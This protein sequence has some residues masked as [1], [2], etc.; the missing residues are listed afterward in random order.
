MICI[1]RCH[2]TARAAGPDGISLPRKAC[3][4]MNFNGDGRLRSRTRRF[5][6]PHFYLRQNGFDFTSDSARCA[7]YSSG[8]RI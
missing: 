2:N 4:S 6:A 5:L 7:N 3:N 1:A 8:L